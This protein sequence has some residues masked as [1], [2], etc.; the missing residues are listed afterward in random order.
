MRIVVQSMQVGIPQD[1]EQPRSGPA[2]IAKLVELELRLAKRLLRQVV[3]VGRR[4][5]EAE[6]VTVQRFVMGIHKVLDAPPIAGPLHEAPTLTRMSRGE[7]D[8]FP[9][10]QVATGSP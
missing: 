7:G 10:R 6:G 9:A 1:A 5:R 2:R 8:L 3:G 4:T